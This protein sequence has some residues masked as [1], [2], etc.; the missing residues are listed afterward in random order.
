[1]PR[2]REAV[3]ILA[4]A[5]DLRQLGKVVLYPINEVDTW[6]QKNIVKSRASKRLGRSGFLHPNYGIPDG[7]TGVSA[8]G[9]MWNG[10]RL[11]GAAANRKG[12]LR[13]VVPASSVN[14]TANPVRVAPIPKIIAHVPTNIIITTSGVGL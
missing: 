1:M 6:N 11:S 8:G 5:T 13:R 14:V 4:A 2:E 12:Y 7:A 9:L 10:A 3:P